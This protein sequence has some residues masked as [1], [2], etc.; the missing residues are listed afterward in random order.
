VLAGPACGSWNTLPLGMYGE[1]SI[2]AERKPNLRKSNL[3][4]KE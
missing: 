4:A 3:A 2:A 1:M